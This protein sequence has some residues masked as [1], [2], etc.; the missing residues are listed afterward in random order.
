MFGMEKKTTLFEFDLESDLKKDPK[1]KQDL[2]KNIE[3]KTGQLKTALR[4]GSSN[5]HFDAYGILLHAYGALQ[6]VIQRVPQGGA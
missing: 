3:S 1:K 5:E 6:K 4:E 2:L